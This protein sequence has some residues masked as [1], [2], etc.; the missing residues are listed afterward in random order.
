MDEKVLIAAGCLPKILE[1]VLKDHEDLERVIAW[2]D[3]LSNEK[4]AKIK[5]LEEKVASMQETLDAYEEA[6]G[7][8]EG[9]TDD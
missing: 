2:R 5:A 6:F 8:I 4:D 7:S 3:R 9:G 1:I